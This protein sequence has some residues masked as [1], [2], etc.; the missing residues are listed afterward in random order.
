MTAVSAH[1]LALG[2]LRLQEELVQV[3]QERLVGLQLLCR[4]GLLR[5][6][7]EAKL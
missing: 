1:E 6:V 5:Q 3:L 4:G 7:G 2:N